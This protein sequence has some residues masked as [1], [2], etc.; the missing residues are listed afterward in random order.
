M[1]ASR[2]SATAAAGLLLLATNALAI[3]VDASDS[4]SLIDA[5]GTV[6]AS[7][8]A[9][10]TGDEEGN[11][12]GLF[13]RQYYFWE[14]GLAWDTLI[15][16]AALTGDDQY[17]DAVSQALQWQVGPDSNYLPPNQTR[18]L[19]ND[20]QSFWALACMTAEETGFA[21]PEDV[22]G[23]DSWLQ[24]A[25]SVFDTQ[26][27]RWDNE[28]CGGGLRWQIFTFNNGYD[29]KNSFS[30]GNFMQLAAR[31]Y[32][33]TQN[34][35]YA[36]WFNAAADWMA[37]VGLYDAESGAVYD[38][39]SVDNDCGDLNHLQW[40][41]ASGILLS[42]YAHMIATN[43]ST[44]QT[45]FLSLSQT[46]RLTAPQPDIVNNATR[47]ESILSMTTSIFVTNSTDVLTEPACIPNQT[48]N[49]D[50]IAYR[51]ILARALATVRDSGAAAD[52]NSTINTI[53]SASAAA[54]GAQ[55]SGGDEG[56]TCGSDWTAESFDGSR[57]LSEDLSALNVLLA[58]LPQRVASG[59]GASNGTEGGD[60]SSSSGSGGSQTESGDASQTSG[61][62]NASSSADAQGE[63]RAEQRAA[64]MFGLLGAVGFAVAFFL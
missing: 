41:G 60:D 36:D 18:N 34:E 32:A 33:N 47:F 21:P 14:D 44:F 26:V 49:I 56:T 25:Q 46:A 6:A 1:R 29:Y 58:N 15:N 37:Q 28:T 22:E 55:C 61:A 38:G 10:Y 57:G 42:A 20:D 52:S 16:Y 53:L 11:V 2:S 12:P 30:N 62:A 19:A 64:S 13:G 50:Q 51:G 5:A 59:G 4:Q 27:S 24:L 3:D 39:T 45:T 31:L 63:N 8:M 40:S 48:C 17:N 35:T 54:A 23:V 43:V 7:I 9:R